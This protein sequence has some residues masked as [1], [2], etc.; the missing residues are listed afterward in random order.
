[1]AI[2]NSDEYI[3]YLEESAA[4]Q[5]ETVGGA[6]DAS[7]QYLK[8][9]E[10]D[11]ISYY[12]KQRSGIYTG[13]RVSAL[14][15]N[16]RLAAYGLAGNAYAKPQSGYSESSRIRSDV[17]MQNALANLGTEQRGAIQSLQNAIRQIQQN[18]AS[19]IGQIETATADKIAAIKQADAQ[20]NINAER[21]LVDYYAKLA[22][23]GA[24]LTD[25]QKAIMSKYGY[26][27]QQLY[28]IYEREQTISKQKQFAQTYLALL[29]GGAS[30][31]PEQASVFESVYGVPADQYKAFLTEQNQKQTADQLKAAIS[32]GD[33]YFN[34]EQINPTSLEDWKNQGLLS[35]SQYNEILNE[36]QFANASIYAQKIDYATSKIAEAINSGNRTGLKDLVTELNSAMETVTTAYNNKE[37]S[38][39]QYDEIK[40]DYDKFV[41]EA[42]IAPY[43]VKTAKAVYTNG[44]EV[45]PYGNRIFRNVIVDVGGTSY[46]VELTNVGSGSTLANE[47]VN[48]G[49]TENGQVMLHNG[50]I[51]MRVNNPDGSIFTISKLQK[52]EKKS[53]KDDYDKLKEALTQ[54]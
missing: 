44:N 41:K 10:P 53:A 51:Y 33:L 40:S 22:Q 1:M 27:Y 32:M 23:S 20:N 3:R 29:E 45:N 2:Y 54:K 17:N 36:Y 37:I 26:D 16:E 13:S 25:E 46:E 8:A 34:G 52:A 5:K 35:E 14:G 18:K 48:K 4:R 7:A 19:A 30:L 42:K 9:Q 11:L 6:Y 28:D 50:N 24:T 47:L 21:S 49:L 43:N 12:D 38:K 15:D 39:S 31:T